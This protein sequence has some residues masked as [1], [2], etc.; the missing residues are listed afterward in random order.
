MFEDDGVAVV[1]FGPKRLECRVAE[2][3]AG[4][5]G[6]EGYTVG[7]QRAEGIVGLGQGA[8]DVREWEGGE[9]A[10]SAGPLGDQFRGVLVDAARHLP[11]VG[12]GPSD[13]AG[14]GH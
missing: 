5:A 14:R 6:H 7:V 9:A 2:V 12:R 3:F 1:E 4:I 10:E 8:V 13:H 11:P